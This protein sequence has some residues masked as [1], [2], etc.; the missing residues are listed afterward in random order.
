MTNETPTAF[1]EA[2]GYLVECRRDA[3]GVHWA[4]LRSIEND[5]FV[6]QKYGRGDTAEAA[7]ERARQ[8]WLTE[9]I[10]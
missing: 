4:S 5:E 2:L 6:V 3:D 10:G 8:R 9:Q 1:F 7:L